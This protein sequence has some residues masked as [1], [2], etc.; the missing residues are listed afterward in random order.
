MKKLEKY[1]KLP[2]NFLKIFLKKTLKMRQI[3]MQK[4]PRNSFRMSH[5]FL[6]INSPHFAL[7]SAYK[8]EAFRT[9]FCMLI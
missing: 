7:F 6:H 3:S 8:F 1:T 4:T 5:C 9:I 2:Y